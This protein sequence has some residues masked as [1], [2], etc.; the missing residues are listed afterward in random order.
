MGSQC[1]EVTAVRSTGLC[2]LEKSLA[3]CWSRKPEGKI[4]PS[5][6]Q[7]CQS[8]A[9]AQLASRVCM[10]PSPKSGFVSS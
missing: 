6:P 2:Y 9:W 3:L 4:Y 1:H 10:I 8:F 7:H 5:C